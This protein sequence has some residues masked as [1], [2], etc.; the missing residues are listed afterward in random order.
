MFAGYQD[1][2]ILAFIMDKDVHEKVG[3]V[4]SAVGGLV[5]SGVEAY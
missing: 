3:E 5:S 4:S 1:L 2:G